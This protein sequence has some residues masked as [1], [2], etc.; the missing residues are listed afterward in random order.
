MPHVC[1]IYRTLEHTLSPTFKGKKKASLHF[2][3]L[4]YCFMVKIHNVLLLEVVSVS[5]NSD[6]NKRG[7]FK[8]NIKK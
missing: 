3:Y 2:A 1:Q 5:R 8:I 4:S 7:V 6:Q